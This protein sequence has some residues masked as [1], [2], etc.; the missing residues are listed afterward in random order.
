MLRMSRVRTRRIEE[1][2]KS[3]NVVQ[4]GPKKSISSVLTR[5]MKVGEWLGYGSND[6]LHEAYYTTVG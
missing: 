4:E 2:M 5:G 6:D 1:M 3:V